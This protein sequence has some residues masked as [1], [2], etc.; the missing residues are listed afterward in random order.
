MYKIYNYADLRDEGFNGTAYN[1]FY[2]FS[3]GE[4]WWGHSGEFQDE[5]DAWFKSLDE[6]LEFADERYPDEVLE[7]KLWAAPADGATKIMF[8][9]RE[10]EWIDG[11]DEMDGDE[12]FILLEKDDGRI[13]IERNLP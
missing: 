11:V 7:D 4:E 3:D 13:K 2:E 5:L 6:A 9:I 8:S 1:V 10:W 12:Y